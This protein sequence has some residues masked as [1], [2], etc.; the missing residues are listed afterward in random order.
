MN[1]ALI[2]SSSGKVVNIIVIDEDADYT[3]EAGYELQTADGAAK[4]KVWNGVGYDARPQSELDAIDEAK[5]DTVFKPSAV[6]KVLYYLGKEQGMFKSLEEMRTWVDDQPEPPA[7]F[8][9]GPPA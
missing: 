1:K 9:G 2:K 8:G 7:T 3:L 6:L 5:M 4:H